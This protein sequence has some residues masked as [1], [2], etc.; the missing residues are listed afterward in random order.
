LRCEGSAESSRS[1][2]HNIAANPLLLRLAIVGDLIGVVV[3]LL[4]V[5][6]LASG[7]FRFL[8]PRYSDVVDKI[9]RPVVF[10]EIAIIL[11]LLIMGAWHGS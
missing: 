6:V 8:A 11:W 9:T 1:A 5:L 4:V 2:A 10:G 7:Y 3:W